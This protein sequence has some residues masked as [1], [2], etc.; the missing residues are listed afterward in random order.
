MPARPAA[1]PASLQ[2]D[3]AYL[4]ETCDGQDNDFNGSTDEGLPALDCSGTPLASCV[5]GVPQ[6]CPVNKPACVGPVTD[7]RPRFVLLVDSSSSML[8]DVAGKPT[9]GDGSAGHL[10]VDTSSDADTVDGNNS[11]LSIAKAALNNILAA[12]PNADFALARFHQDVTANRSC[13]AAKWLE[14][15]QACCSYD[16]PRDNVAPAFPSAP[17]CNLSALYSAGFPASL[18]ANI[19]TG[20]SSQSACINYSGS[21]GLPRRG[22]DL[23]VGFDKPLQQSLMWIDGRETRF[24]PSTA[25]GDHCS[26][27]AGG[28]CELRGNGPRPIAD[29]L[30]GVADYL[31]PIVA[32][33]AAVP[34]RKYAVILLTTGVESCRGNPI[35][36][37]TALRTAV[38][39]TSISTYVI[40]FSVLA[41]EQAQLNAIA[42]AGGTGSAF[43]ASDQS[44]L[45]SALATISANASVTE[46]CNGLD[47]DCDGLIDEDYPAKGQPCDD[48]QRGI[49]RGTGVLVCG[50]S[51]M[52]TVC[53]ITS[54]GLAARAE[55]CNGLDDDCEG[56]VDEG[57]VC[58]ACSPSPELCNGEDDDCNGVTDNAPIDVNVTCGLARGECAPGLSVCSAGVLECV[59]GVG[60][61]AEICN[62]LD[63]DCD[64]VTDG[65]AATCYPGPA[66]TSGV[67]AC[68]PGTQACTAAPGS[69]LAQWG[70]CLDAVLPS[71]EV[72][73]GI[74]QDCNGATD[75]AATDASGHLTGEPCCA[76]GA[77]CGVGA[78]TSGQWTCAGSQV[79]C[80]GGTGPALETCNG[81]DDDCNGATDDLPGHGGPCLTAGRCAG[82]LRCD[83]SGAAVCEPTLALEV[84]NGADDD[85]N[86]TVD[87]ESALA[88]NDPAVGVACQAP[89]AP[90][91]GA[92]CQAGV[93]KCLRGAV[94]CV[95]AVVPAGERC[96]GVDNDCDGATDDGADLC[97]AGAECHLGAC[98][99]PCATGPSACPGL[100]HCVDGWCV[101]PPDEGWPDSGQPPDADSPVGA[102]AAAPGLDASVLSPA[103]AAGIADAAQALPD[104]G[105][106]TAPDSGSDT[107]LAG[108][109]SC[110]TGAS[111]VTPSTLG[112]LLL[113]LALTSRRKAVRP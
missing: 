35:A 8:N 87:D 11:R 72:C 67:G 34:C 82:V 30:D 49:C 97:P 54:P 46:R 25:P 63:D 77:L 69:G 85:C 29:A 84:C 31:K 71:V 16:D 108:G 73:D 100:F 24:D 7:T 14:C 104:G 89:V 52:S 41:S 3:G 17:G 103:D 45:A 110:Q 93:T 48:G 28:D 101:K 109:C 58:G 106:G 83:A 61:K 79:V 66:G 111:P 37:V 65:L 96:D 94:S 6:Q 88:Q 22:A 43:F 70:P 55:T 9:F 56:L 78:C 57:G 10:G 107:A 98:R 33:D 36:S 18:A 99:I 21:C 76:F 5:G 50:A 60:P 74:D 19:N 81:L 32:C 92:P 53:M 1:A 2:V 47:D 4:G 91:D 15:E 44:G 62:G 20:W 38:P 113:G 86:G 68:H 40:G 13:L 59:G 105:N 90:N 112:L 27:A 23:L 42:S 12:F 102:D 95:G 39:G 75:D 51:A 80:G 26:F 64:G